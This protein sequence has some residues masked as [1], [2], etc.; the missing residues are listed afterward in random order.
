MRI[1]FDLDKEQSK[2]KS[3]VNFNMHMRYLYL[4]VD[5]NS[6]ITISRPSLLSVK[7]VSNTIYQR[8]PHH[9]LGSHTRVATTSGSGLLGGDSCIV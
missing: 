1:H 6:Y 3:C 2:I 5:N 7:S 4:P 8:E 9:F